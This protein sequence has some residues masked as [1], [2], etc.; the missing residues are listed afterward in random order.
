MP[1][2]LFPTEATLPDPTGGVLPSGLFDG[3]YGYLVAIVFFL[4]L[5]AR[6]LRRYREIDVTTYRTEIAS[7]KDDVQVLTAEVA[8]LRDQNFSGARE[9][10]KEK[11]DLIRENA[12]MRARCAANGIPTHD[13]AQ[14]VIAE[15]PQP[16][17][18]TT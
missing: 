18:A 12:L 10:A 17:E 4:F 6:E 13:I 5:A 9:S 3:P 1:S 15:T 7:L 11:E 8:L 16:P 2:P 14:H